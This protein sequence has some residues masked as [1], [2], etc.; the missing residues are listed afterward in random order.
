[1]VAL[2]LNLQW[3]K[4]RDPGLS[5]L[6]RATRTA[7]VMPALFAFGAKVL[8]NPTLATFAA[9]GSFAM[10]LL[11]DFGGTLR[12]RAAAQISLVVTGSVFVCLGTLASRSVWLAAVAMLIIGFAVLFVGVVSSVLASA[13][14]SL[15]LGFILPVTL[16]APVSS[17][18]DRVG[19]WLLAG[20]VSL[21]AVT[22]L[23]P[24][25]VRDP[26]R[27]LA[28]EACRLLALR[29]QAEVA[30][31]LDGADRAAAEAAAQAATDAVKKLRMGF[32]ATPYR[33]TG[34]TTAARTVVRLVDE[35]GWLSTIVEDLP[36]GLH[37]IPAD[38]SVCAVKRSAAEVLAIGA[39]LLQEPERELDGLH[40][41]LQRLRQA[42]TDMERNVTATLP[43]RRI[44]MS[45]DSPVAEFVTS[46]EPSFRAQEM[47]FAISAIASNIELTATAQQRN[48]WEKVL[49]HQ[50]DGV[51]GPLAS[52]QERAGAHVE[53]HSVWLHN[54]VR[55]AIALAA[56][57]AIADLTG[58]QHSFWVVLGTLSVLRSSALNT[59][60]NA[61]RGLAGTTAGFIVGGVLVLAIGTD[62]TLLWFLLPLAILLAGLAPAISF[63]AGQAGFTITLLILFNIIEPTGWRVG[64]VRVED[65][66]IGCAVSL[67]V[68]ALFWP[69][70]AGSALGLALAE[71]YQE[72][73][74]YLRRAIAFGLVRCDAASPDQDPPT[75]DEQR[76]AAAA[77]R[78]DDAFRS[79]LAERGTKHIPLATVSSLITGVAGLRLTAAAVLDLWGREDGTPAGDRTA[80]RRE[81]LSASE[82]VA[83][84]YES[85]AHALSGF[86][87]V[88]EALP[89][90]KA[91]DGR[92]IDAVRR[93]LNGED[94][95]GT[96]TAVRMI[97]TGDHLDA[98]RRLQLG[99]VE[100]AR[101]VA[102][103][104]RRYLR[105][106]VRQHRR[107]RVGAVAA[108]D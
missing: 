73:A 5:A 1:M 37:P 23:W 31:L 86:G 101:A 51:A 84:W 75:A 13:S 52:A 76:A 85:M 16:S 53:R 98:A 11:V 18:P 9:F 29:L 6:R 43:V 60:Q 32:F 72:S 27:G 107:G 41:Q 2:V 94:G 77:R 61:L 25:P 87:Q 64:L 91:A 47:S 15:L 50:P 104:E 22:V 100:P 71:A 36:V 62:T 83:G 80:A 8:D 20:V 90:D 93:D 17:I 65:V 69:R 10:L 78:L 74:A 28:A 30:H 19:G 7:I 21:V 34:L 26:L 106:R 3:L 70:G 81:L 99:L 96:A 57:V 12:E 68:G 39:R 95:G 49:G 38:L 92:L 58:V 55:G 82:S 42:L 89:H 103:Q 14:T 4:K 97:W 45:D 33:P 66:A 102:E 40:A 56:A 79:F 24:A 88:A 46:L 35:V 54:S 108:A 44:E 63:A 59:G 67:A 48:W 105:S